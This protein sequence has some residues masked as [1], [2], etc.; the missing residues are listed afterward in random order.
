MKQ[1]AASRSQDLWLANVAARR[2][3]WLDALEAE[4]AD[5]ISED[6]IEELI[7]E[8]TFAM[9]YPWQYEEYFANAAAKRLAAETRKR[10]HVH[11]LTAAAAAGPEVGGFVDGYPSD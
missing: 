7:C 1:E 11:Q 9:K 5:W 2:S 8:D 4:A 10:M 3:E 6:R